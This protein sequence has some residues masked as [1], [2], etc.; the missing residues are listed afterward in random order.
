MN[1]NLNDYQ[2]HGYVVL[3]S[4]INKSLLKDLRN[5]IKK[6]FYKNSKYKKK[7]FHKDL[8]KFRDTKK[9]KFGYFFDTLQ[10]LSI[11]YQILTQSKILSTTNKLL[12]KSKNCISLTDIALRVDPPKDDRNSLKWHQDSSYFRQNNYGFNGVVVWL[13]VFEVNKKTGTI[14]LLE[15]SHKIGP[16]NIKRKKA[17]KNFSSQRNIDERLLKNFRKVEPTSIKLGDAIL[18]NM[19]MVHKSSN[20]LSKK[21]RISLIGRYHNTISGDFNSGLNIFRYS[22]KNFDKEVHGH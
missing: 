16:Q 17:K 7:N 8:F 2:K 22:N 19:D 14:C 21:N 1:F 20:N 5:I 10:T 15:Q 3:R 11:N 13:P 12:K 18:M 9:E 6:I 4:I